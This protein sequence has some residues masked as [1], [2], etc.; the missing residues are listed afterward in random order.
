M[1]I[2]NTTADLTKLV[3]GAALG[4][5]LKS[6]KNINASTGMAALMQQQFGS[7]QAQIQ[8]V[9][10]EELATLGIPPFVPVFVSN[11]GGSG[12]GSVWWNNGSYF[13]PIGNTL[14][15]FSLPGG[16]TTP[17]TGTPPTWEDALNLTIP[18][19]A[20]SHGAILRL[21][22]Y[23][24]ADQG[25]GGKFK[26]TINFTT[27]PPGAGATDFMDEVTLAENVAQPAGKIYRFRHE[28]APLNGL[29]WAEFN[30]YPAGLIAN[31]V[32]EEDLT[33]HLYSKVVGGAGNGAYIVFCDVRIDYP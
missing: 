20:M 15:V 12:K 10:L 29:S 30:N 3:T 9:T 6:Q 27:D 24:G 7:D 8:S 1:A 28:P 13:V 32:P 23:V 11:F 21:E 17:G 25:Y 26:G 4:G 18:A 5:G 2:V 19:I 14:Q 33:L 22:F 31:V 16:W